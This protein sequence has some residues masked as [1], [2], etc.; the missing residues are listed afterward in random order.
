LK[1]IC[2]KSLYYCIDDKEGYS[3]LK[4]K[5][6]LIESP[7]GTLA[8]IFILQLTFHKNGYIISN[9]KYREF[10]SVFEKEWVE[11]RRIAFKVIDDIICLNKIIVNGGEKNG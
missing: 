10:Y 4:T 7:E 3:Q 5:G 2:D 6:L 11:D 9:D 8:D 1:I